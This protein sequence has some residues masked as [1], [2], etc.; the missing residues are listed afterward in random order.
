MEEWN[1]HPIWS[2]IKQLRNGVWLIGQL[3]PDTFVPTSTLVAQKNVRSTKQ[4]KLILPLPSPTV[5]F[6]WIELNHASLVIVL[7]YITLITLIH[8]APF[9]GWS[10][11]IMLSKIKDPTHVRCPV[12]RETPQLSWWFVMMM[13][14]PFLSA[15]ETSFDHI[16]N[17]RQISHWGFAIYIYIYI[18]IY[19]F[20]A[21]FIISLFFPRLR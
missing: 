18:Y 2:L 10:H 7:S 11:P 9:N 17:W 3:P 20:L 19:I 8:Q 12:N 21:N 13:T 1:E 14:I 6:L 4:K 5:L 16:R 15:L